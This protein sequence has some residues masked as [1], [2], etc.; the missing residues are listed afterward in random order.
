MRKTLLLRKRAPYQKSLRGNQKS[1]RKVM[2]DGWIRREVEEIQAI[3][4]RNVDG[5]LVRK[6]IPCPQP[7]C[8]AGVFSVSIAT[9]KYA[10]SAATQSSLTSSPPIAP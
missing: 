4:I 9:G 3:K 6:G 5:E 2:L 1:P 8:G 7:G 10:A